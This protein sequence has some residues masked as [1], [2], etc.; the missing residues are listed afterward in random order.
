MNLIKLLKYE[1]TETTTKLSRLKGISCKI[2]KMIVLLL[3]YLFINLFV[4]KSLFIIKKENY[5]P[6]SRKCLLKLDLKKSKFL[7]ICFRVSLYNYK[8]KL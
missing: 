2:L 1:N 3:I 7:I 4:F 8:E 5:H 6:L